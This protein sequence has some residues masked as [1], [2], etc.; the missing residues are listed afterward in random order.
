MGTS[1]L[2]RRFVRTGIRPTGI[3]VALMALQSA[4]PC[5]ASEPA[6]APVALSDAL[7]GGVLHYRVKT[8][9]TLL[10]I[11]GRFGATLS[12]LVRANGI[13]NPDRIFP[14]EILLVD[15]RHIVP[16]SG[17]NPIVIN[18]PQKM[19]FF[20]AG[21]K[22]ALAAPVALGMRSWQTPI[23][24]FKVVE[25]K[26]HPCWVV[27]KSIQAD[28]RRRGEKVVKKVPPGPENPLGNYWLGLSLGDYGIHGTDAPSSIFGYT[29]HGCIRLFPDAIRA[30]FPRV[31]VGTRGVIV[32]APILVARTPDGRVYLEAHPDAYDKESDLGKIFERWAKRHPDVRFDREKARRVMLERAGRPVDVSLR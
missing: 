14:G 17:G 23:G 18:I 11:R 27:P 4:L 7:T 5:Y 13:R 32:Y 24:P 9:D 25:K 6:G 15:N 8:G 12:T 21:G 19:L 16:P 22:L 20:Y 29:T 31:R 1:T 2:Q 26:A 28:M 30:L 3:L 10:S